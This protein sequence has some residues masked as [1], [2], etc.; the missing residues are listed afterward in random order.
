MNEEE[1]GVV[2]WKDA[3][4]L[5]SYST[6]TQISPI[7]LLCSLPEQQSP[8]LNAGLPGNSQAKDLDLMMLVG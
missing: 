5:P 6:Q 1:P 7:I 4:P 3:W 8:V 2:S